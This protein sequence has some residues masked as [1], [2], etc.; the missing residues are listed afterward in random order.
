M[1]ERVE[2]VRC[3]TAIL[4]P[5][6]VEDLESFVADPARYL[7]SVSEEPLAAARLWSER[8]CRNPFGGDGVVSIV[9]YGQELIGP[10]WW[11]D[12]TGVWE[13][14]INCVEAFRSGE[15]RIATLSGQ[16]VELSLRRV[17]AGALFSI[18]RRTTLVDPG[19]FIQG[20]LDG[21]AEFSAWVHEYL[22]TCDAPSVERINRLR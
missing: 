18:D 4:I 20:V 16:P 12:V 7:C 14:L 15:P 3:D 8:L 21:A 2:P 5:S 19:V 1:T 11:D 9:Y 13:A 6:T 17:P 10:S 22:G